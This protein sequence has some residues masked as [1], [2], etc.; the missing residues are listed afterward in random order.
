MGMPPS[1]TQRPVSLTLLA[2]VIQMNTRRVAAR[3]MQSSL[4]SFFGQKRSIA[5]G[6]KP[7]K[8]AKTEAKTE[9]AAEPKSEP[10]APKL[11]PTAQEAKCE[12]SSDAA[13]NAAPSAAANMVR[14]S[15][16]SKSE[17][18]TAIP[19]LS[20]SQ[21]FANI[22]ATTKRLEITKHCSDLFSSVL[23]QSQGN[24]DSLAKVVYLCINRLGPDYE[25]LELGLGESIIVKALAESTGRSM[26]DVKKQYVKLGDLG[27]V[28]LT[29]K[30]SQTMMFSK[31]KPLTVDT[32]FA[33]LKDIATSTGK[34]SQQRKIAI[35]KGLLIQCRGEESKYIVRSLEG[36]L[37]IG[38]AEK[39]VLIA[40]SQAFI[41]WEKRGGHPTRISVDDGEEIIKDAFSQMPN[42][43]KIIEAALAHG[44]G[45]LPANVKLT[46]G[47]PLKPMLAKPTKSISEVLDRFQDKLFT[48][49]Y[50]YDGERAQ[51]H[52]AHGKMHVYSRNMEDMSERYPDIID[53]LP[54]I[55]KDANVD[56]ILDCEAVAWDQAEQKI[57]P[58]QVLST[59]K[60][61]DVISGEIKVRVQLFAF[62]ILY[63]NGESLLSRSLAERRQILYNNFT[64]TPGKLSMA[65]SMNSRE[66]DDIQHFLDQ[67]VKD[68]CEGLM[69][70]AL[71]GDESRY[72]PSKR[73]INWLKVKKDY[74]E[75]IG[76]SLDLVVLGA[77]FGKGKRTNWYGG[78]LLGC[79]NSESEEYE[80]VCK[81]GTGFSEANLQRFYTELSPIADTRPKSY[82]S[83]DTAANQQPDVWFEP[84]YV[85]EVLTADLSLSP[86]YQAGRSELDNGKGISLRFPRFI[87]E[88][89]DK[90]AEDSTSTEQIIQMYE[91]QFT[92]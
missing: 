10:V 46:P 63:F 75:G 31:P 23:D 65:T 18:G 6:G 78:F 89:E 19:Y 62:D 22:E 20:I 68:N 39:T 67:S 28:A 72:E 45:N 55:A 69:V 56:F 27:Q 90:S 4:D 79:Y 12:T 16:A 2:Y 7:A 8:A 1:R 5:S 37:R 49:E 83:H 26:Q 40:L 36:K 44:L 53:I 42:Y 51:V 59:R 85:W 17:L 38:L 57:L 13:P 47:I 3:L 60:R 70:K 14:D 76:D 71:E 74:L 92:E 41:N 11:E 91:R 81:I 9:P 66:L 54:T 58:F 30:K 64:P 29:S 25:G 77:Y 80:T 52:N 34:D 84:K 50:K 86:V 61:K 73:S 43:E 21:A 24:A 32:V 48:C 15:G 33:K 35:I 82:I 87:R 88:R